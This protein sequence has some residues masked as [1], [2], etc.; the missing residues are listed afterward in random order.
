M[1]SVERRCCLL[2]WI[3]IF[4][5]SFQRYSGCVSPYDSSSVGIT[6]PRGPMKAEWPSTSD[7]PT[8]NIESRKWSGRRDSNSRHSPWEG[9]T[10]PLS[11]ARTV[12]KEYHSKRKTT[13]SGAGGG[14]RTRMASLE[15][16]NFTTKL[17]PLRHQSIPAR[18]STRQ[19]IAFYERG[20]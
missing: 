17:R 18:E 8:S 5:A 12:S 2:R 3:L 16:W 14:N 11:Y 7:R 20:A 10:L 19:S 9:D 6:E 15:G 1:P 4:G 13:R